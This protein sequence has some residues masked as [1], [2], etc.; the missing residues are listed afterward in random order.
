MKKQSLML[1]F[2]LTIAFLLGA[3]SEETEEPNTS[4][5]QETNI[6]EDRVITIQDKTFTKDDLEFYTLMK[7]IQIETNRYFDLEQQ[8][9]EE[10]KSLNDYWD[11]QLSYYDNINVQLQHLVELYAISLLAEEKHY[12]VPSEKLE[13]EVETFRSGVKDIEKANQLI[14]DYGEARYNQNIYDYTRQ[15]ILRDRVVADLEE[16]I[17]EEQPTILDQ[18]LNYVLSKQFEELYIDQVNDLVIEVHVK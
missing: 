7:K 15:S 16:Q 12:D 9:D 10:R 5:Q 8:N 6:L 4:K 17:R 3:C 14:L 11:E 18:E 13:K 1:S 2:L